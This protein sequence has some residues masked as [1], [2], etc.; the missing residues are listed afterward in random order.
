[1]NK[2]YQKMKILHIAIP[3]ELFRQLLEN[4]TMEDIIN[5]VNEHLS[6]L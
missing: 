4:F 3:D 6:G 5:Q 2:Q 1:M